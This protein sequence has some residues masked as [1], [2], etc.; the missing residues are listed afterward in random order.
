[1]PLA[2]DAKVIWR[3]IEEA[4]I[5]KTQP[6]FFKHKYT[7]LQW[8]TAQD[9]CFFL[10]V[11]NSCSFSLSISNQKQCVLRRGMGLFRLSDAE[12]DLV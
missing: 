8:N 7:P 11:N 10:S 9:K 5:M 3:G 4:F 2:E 6:L 1:M 12:L